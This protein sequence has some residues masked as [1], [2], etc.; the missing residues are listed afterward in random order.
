M[1]LRY[2]GRV[3]GLLRQPRA[4]SG[5]TR[6]RVEA[7]G[8]RLSPRA[9][10]LGSNGAARGP[11]AGHHLISRRWIAIIAGGAEGET[12]AARRARG[13]DRL[14][15]ADRRRPVRSEDRRAASA[16]ASRGWRALLT[17]RVA[18]GRQLLREVLAGPLRFTPEGR[19][20][21]F[22]GEAAIGR[23]RAGMAGLHPPCWRPQRDSRRREYRSSGSFGPH[24]SGVESADI[25]GG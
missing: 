13:D 22:E 7:A 1:A 3:T 6:R 17:A 11:M 25:F 4:V 20:Y 24:E 15:R 16:R 23:L 2:R 9:A 14:A 10:S 8:R 12:G 19:T 21:R 5:A 18:D